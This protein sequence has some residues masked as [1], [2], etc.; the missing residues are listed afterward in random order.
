MEVFWN[1]AQVLRMIFVSKRKKKR[2]DMNGTDYLSGVRRPHTELKSTD[3]K[4]N[5][6]WRR[7]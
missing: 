5:I 2:Q 3:E 7:S 4:T 1:T 6:I